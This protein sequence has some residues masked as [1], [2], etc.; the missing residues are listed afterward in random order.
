MDA[1]WN[2]RNFNASTGVRVRRNRLAMAATT[3]VEGLG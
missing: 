1:N 3:A 2:W